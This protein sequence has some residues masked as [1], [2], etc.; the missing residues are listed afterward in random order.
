[1]ESGSDQQALQIT[2]AASSV[3]NAKA[4]GEEDAD[5]AAKR[6]EVNETLLLFAREG[7]NLVQSLQR[8]N[9]FNLWLIGKT[10]CRNTNKNWK[11]KN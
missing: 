3:L 9:R 8:I 4:D 1:M 11:G 5:A 2:N 6:Q 7:K 10:K